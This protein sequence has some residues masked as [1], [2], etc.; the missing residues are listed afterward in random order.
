[1]KSVAK[2]KCL[3]TTL[4]NLQSFIKKLKEHFTKV[5]PDSIGTNFFFSGTLVSRNI[6]IKI[7]RNV[8]LPHVWYVCVVLC[9][10]LNQVQ[11]LIIIA[12]EG[13]WAKSRL[14]ETG[15][16]NFMN[17]APHQILFGSWNEAE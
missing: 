13:V 2:V 3:G 16:G 7:C 11:R 6:K 17:S 14:E 9:F 8:N 12:N 10:S 4:A 5:A 1:L 15:N